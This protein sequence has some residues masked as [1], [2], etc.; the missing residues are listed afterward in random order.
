MTDVMRARTK[1][2]QKKEPA[3]SS[4]KRISIYV[5]VE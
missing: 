1:V 3:S 2:G 5:F 4:Y